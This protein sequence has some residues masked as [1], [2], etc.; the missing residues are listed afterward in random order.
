[1]SLYAANSSESR[2][3]KSVSVTTSSESIKT[4]IR[5]TM[6]PTTLPNTV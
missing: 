1:M 2:S 4:P 5:Q 6:T 3:V